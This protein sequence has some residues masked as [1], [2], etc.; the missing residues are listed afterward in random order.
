MRKDGAEA[1]NQCSWLE[2]PS[3]KKKACGLK[4]NGVPLTVQTTTQS[5]KLII[6]STKNY[7][8]E[9]SLLIECRNNKI[10]ISIE[11]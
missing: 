6:F 3:I 9:Q 5:K 1:L 2:N 4:T 8:K 10:I 7:L 11:L